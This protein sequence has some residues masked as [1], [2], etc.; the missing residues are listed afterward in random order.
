MLR[1]PRKG[2]A[3]G[4]RRSIRWQDQIA[5]WWRI[6]TARRRCDPWL[7]VMGPTH[8][9]TDGER[10]CGSCG[11]SMPLDVSFCRAC[12]ASM[13]VDPLIGTQ[14]DG[15][16]EVVR[17]V[18]Q[19]GMGTVYEVQH[20][21]L[22][23]RFAMKVM[24]RDLTEL[25]DFTARFEREAMST[26]KQKHPNCVAVT[27]FGHA[28]TGELYLVMEYL[29]GRPLT[30]LMGRPM[31]VSKTLDVVR[32]IL[33]ALQH[34]HSTGIVH[35]DVKSDNVMLVDGADKGWLVKVLDFGLAVPAPARADEHRITETQLVCGTPTYMAPEQAAQTGVDERSDLYAVGVILWYL[36]TGRPPFSADNPVDL[37]KR[38]MT[39]SAPRLNRVAPGVFSKSL[40]RAVATALQRRPEDRFASAEAFLEA[41]TAVQHE[42]GGGLATAP[43][44]AVVR[45][46]QRM[47]RPWVQ[48]YGDWYRCVEGK[49]EP[50][51][52]SRLSAL[53][54]SAGG[55]FLLV[56]AAVGFLTTIAGAL[57]LALTLSG[58][59]G[60]SAMANPNRMLSGGVGA[61]AEGS[62]VS[63]EKPL[64][65]ARRATLIRLLISKGACREAALDAEA[66]LRDRPA[67]ALGYDLLG[68]AQMCRGRVGPALDAYRRAVALDPRYKRD[69]GIIEDV[70][71]LLSIRSTRDQ[72]VDF[73]VRELGTAGLAPLLDA[74][75]SLDRHLRHSAVEAVSRLGSRSQIDW[76]TVSHLDLEQL[77]SCKERAEAVNHLRESGDR[78]ALQVLLEA[79]DARIGKGRGRRR[80][81]K[82]A[83]VRA[84]IKEAISRLEKKL[85]G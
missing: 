29:E 46:I 49:Q 5:P 9:T 69:S 61:P 36:L 73:L 77:K 50:R 26:S 71:A 44:S 42:P 85:K 57:V 20:L 2:R 10:E 70:G 37:L 28:E 24:R 38:K 64:D 1:A 12:G 72:A 56:T 11:A 21:R 16:Y 32:Q 3:L 23:K 59:G 34:A 6:E 27:D 74:T 82:H 40:Q 25:P 83:C 33:L 51:W 7:T 45:H 30:E 58:D 8:I 17:C 18:G 76:V 22:K 53:F 81:Y 4:S 43:H 84:Q 31:P 39:Q 63:A 79:R 52:G 80:R 55:R 78:R 41:L 14:I 54:T 15:R 60:A 48:A 62:A 65:L 35:R 75:T 47:A 66:L 68:G 13:H 19:G 67:L